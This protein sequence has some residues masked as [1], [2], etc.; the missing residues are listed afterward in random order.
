MDEIA[1]SQGTGLGSSSIFNRG[2][3]EPKQEFIPAYKPIVRPDWGKEPPPQAP[4][5]TADRSDL[6]DQPAEQSNQQEPHNFEFHGITVTEDNRDGLNAFG[7]IAAKLS[8]NQDQ[9]RGI[10]TGYQAFEAKQRA[11][12]DKFDERSA[13]S[14][15]AAM[16]ER[17]SNDAGAVIRTIRSFLSRLPAGMGDAIRTARL[18]S[19]VRIGDDIDAISA[20]FDLALSPGRT[21][22][23]GS[24]SPATATNPVEEYRQIQE[25][26]RKNQGLYVKNEA[27]QL[28]ER[29]II[30]ELLESGRM[31]RYGNL[32]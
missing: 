9:F 3:P 26:R 22:E 7:S 29:Q 32:K 5:T 20:L 1:E 28:R 15:K 23:R 31:D 21:R 24:A 2:T 30:D 16:G 4:T 10:A 11:E 17:F 25:Y 14:G 6:A 18:P 12:M 13:E 27:M 19:G 8:L